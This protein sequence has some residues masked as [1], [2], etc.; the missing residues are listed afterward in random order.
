MTDFDFYFQCL[1]LVL[2][3]YN[4]RY[5]KR[6]IDAA[7]LMAKNQHISQA[8]KE[9]LEAMNRTR[10]LAKEVSPSPI[11]EH[12]IVD[13]GTSPTDPG[14]T[15]DVGNGTSGGTTTGTPTEGVRTIHTSN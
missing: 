6:E 12:T 7:H 4:R 3:C 15:G 14:G 10:E 2:F 1:L 5:G 11:V 8:P 9:A 13:N